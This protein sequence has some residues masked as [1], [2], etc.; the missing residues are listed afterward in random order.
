MLLERE[1]AGS[2]QVEGGPGDRTR[3]RRRSA[4]REAAVAPWAGVRGAGDALGWRWRLG[5]G[6]SRADSQYSCLPP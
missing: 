3:A 2:R 1:E 5:L 6:L 4:F